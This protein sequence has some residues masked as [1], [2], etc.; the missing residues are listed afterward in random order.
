MD[1]R[2]NHPE[3]QGAGW[4][5]DER[6]YGETPWRDAGPDRYGSE[7]ALPAPETR[8]GTNGYPLGERHAAGERFAAPEPADRFGPPGSTDRFGPPGSADRFG[9]PEPADRFTQPGSAD[10]F[11]AAEPADRFGPPEPGDRFGPPGSG[12]RFGPPGPP[13]RFGPPGSGDRFGAGAGAAGA[14]GGGPGSPHP[15]S[16]PGS[17]PSDGSR[18]GG[19]PVAGDPG[20]PPLGAYPIVQ[21]AR[22]GP[23]DGPTGPI[24]PVGARGRDGGEPATEGRRSWLGS[25]PPGGD[26]VYRSRRPAIAV[27]LG[28]LLVIFEI[29]ALRVLLDSAVGGPVLVGGAVA[30]MFLVIG[31]P[32]FTVGLYGLATGGAT[33]TDPVRAWL[34][35]PG[36]YLMVG[37]VLFVAAALAA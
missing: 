13:D 18:A 31:L 22:Q 23:M 24:P 10:R 29:L 17:G 19:G 11:P 7:I 26:G 1:A 4:Y 25:G 37:L 8:G 6:G 30:G 33:A 9:A 35:P 14:A 15:A 32:I 3:G 34:R 27:V 16:G 2:D 5:P 12:D 36:A 21:P 28:A 20:Q